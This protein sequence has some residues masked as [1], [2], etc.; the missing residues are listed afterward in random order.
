[1]IGHRV[2]TPARL[3]LTGCE[4]LGAPRKAQSVGASHTFALPLLFAPHA[5]AKRTLAGA[6]V[7]A[8]GI[9]LVPVRA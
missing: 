5:C 7:V 1:M 8:P 4:I 2:R 3:A 9:W 6:V